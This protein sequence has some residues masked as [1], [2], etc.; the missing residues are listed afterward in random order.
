VATMQL[1]GECREMGDDPV[2]W[3]EHL[4]SGIGKMV[5][6]DIVMG[7]ELAGCVEAPVA[8]SLGTADWGWGPGFDRT[9]WLVALQSFDQ[10][11][12]YH[13]ILKGLFERL[14]SHSNLTVRRKLVVS[15]DHWYRSDAY[16]AI[17]QVAGVD[18]T[19]H[20]WHQI[21]TGA[22]R[23]SGWIVNRATGRKQF[24]SYEAQI[25]DFIHL[26]TAQFIGGPLAQ[27]EEPSPSALAPRVRQVLRCILEGDGDKQIA[28]RLHLSP[29]TVNQYVKVIYKHFLVNSRTEL[30]ARWVR[31]GWTNRCAWDP[32]TD[33]A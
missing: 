16:E 7:G 22:D 25:V 19:I 10:N 23:H 4:F 33:D 8:Q 27:F 13:P 28:Q 26:Q 11:P 3:R 21:P 29:H 5:S 18:Q 12:R 6:A 24:S 14:E 2:I 31:R 20:S 17:H 9:G 30:M 15:D 32:Q 1:L